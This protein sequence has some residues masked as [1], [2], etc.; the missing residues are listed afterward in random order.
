ME[1]RGE[2]ELTHSMFNNIQPRLHRGG[3]GKREKKGTS[4]VKI[5]REREEEECYSVDLS[6][7]IPPARE[8]K[9]WQKEGG[10]K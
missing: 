7:S 1:G 9:E 5:F 10:G 8:K 3:E 2:E 6:F 4:S